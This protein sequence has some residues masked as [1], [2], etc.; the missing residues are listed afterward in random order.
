MS[1]LYWEKKD[2][3]QAHNLMEQAIELCKQIGYMEGIAFC[4]AKL[5]NYV[6]YLVIKKLLLPFLLNPWFFSRSL[7]RN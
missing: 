5:A 1:N 2:Y 6:K 3:Y 4:T 7:G